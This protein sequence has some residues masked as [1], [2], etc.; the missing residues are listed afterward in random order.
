MTLK[1]FF[2]EIN[3]LFLAV[4]IRSKGK[5]ENKHELEHKNDD[6]LTKCPRTVK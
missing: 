2:C 4:T 5:A 3:N 1:Y 6:I